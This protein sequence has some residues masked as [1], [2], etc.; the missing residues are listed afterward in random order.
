MLVASARVVYF[1]FRGDLNFCLKNLKIIFQLN[2][3]L[4]ED[5]RLNCHIT[6]FSPAV[7]KFVEEG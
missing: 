6:D 4:L 1:S 5:C 3:W 2:S 7:R